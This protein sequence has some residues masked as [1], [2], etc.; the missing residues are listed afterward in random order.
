[1]INEENLNKMYRGLVEDKE[2]TTLT[3][4]QLNSYGFNLND[5]TDLIH[6]GVL[7]ENKEGGL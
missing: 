5:L 1:M 2:L 4:K 7:K 6:D 3:I